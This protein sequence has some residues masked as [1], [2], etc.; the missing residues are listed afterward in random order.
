MPTFDEIV[1]ATNSKKAS[2]APKSS[3]ASK[4]KNTESFDAIVKRTNPQSN[5]AGR[6]V[7][8]EYIN[9]FVS[10]VN[11]YFKDSKNA[12][13]TMDRANAQETTRAR[14]DALNRLN[15]QH[16]TIKNWLYDNRTNIS[17]ANY[18]EI[19]KMLDSYKNNSSEIMNMLTERSDAFSKMT[20]DDYNNYLRYK[21][22][23]V[24]DL[25]AGQKEIDDLEAQLAQM[26]QDNRYNDLQQ[27]INPTKPTEPTRQDI[28]YNPHTMWQ[29]G[30]VQ[31]SGITEEEKLRQ[32]IAQKQQYLNQAKHIQESN[33]YADTVN[34]ADFD[35][36][37]DFVESDDT[38]YNWINDA[39]FRE[40]YESLYKDS[41][42]DVNSDSRFT[43]KNYDQINENEIA[44]FNYYYAKGGKKAAK[45]Y[46]DN[47]QETLNKR[48][49]DE[50]FGTVKDNVAAE[51][52]FGVAAG[53]N[54]FGT[55]VMN[56]FK[57]KADYIP[58]SAYQIASGMVREDLADNG[59][60]PEWMGENSLAQIA[61]D[62]VTTTANMA[63][64]I[65]VGMATGGTAGIALMGLSAA[66]GAYQQ[67]LNEGFDKAQARGYSILVGASEAV[68]EKVLGGISAVGGN[69]LGLNAVKNI[70]N[71]DNA[72]KAIA[73]RLGASVWS[74]FKEEY[75][76][77]V[78]DPV[79]RNLMMHTGEDVKLVSYE[80]IYSGILGALTGAFMEAPF[81]IYGETKTA[82]TGRKIK[83]AG[84]VNDLAKIGNT[85][86]PET[87][88]YK[89]AGKVT[90]DTGAYT[91]G[92]LFNEV[93]ARLTEQNISEIAEVLMKEGMGENEAKQ[94]ARIFAY[95]V[96]GGTMPDAFAAAIEADT[97]LA[98]AARQVLF[99]D[100]TTWNQRSQGYRDV[101][102]KLAED[103]VK[104]KTAPASK[105]SAPA[106]N[107]AEAKTE[108]GAE[109]NVEPA[110]YGSIQNIKNGKVT[111]KMTDGTEVDLK[112]ADL[113]PEDSV[114][115]ETIASIDGISAEDASGIFGI[116]KAGSKNSQYDAI[117][118]REAYRY[119]YYGLT[120]KM[121]DENGTF[122]KSLTPE[123]RK[124][125][126]EMGQKARQQKVE[127][128][129]FRKTDAKKAPGK[130]HY[131]GDRTVLNE[132]QQVSLKAM[133]RIAS[134]LGVQ[135][136]IFESEVGKN[137]K[138]IGENGW[139]DPKDGS[140]H[141]DLYAGQDGG[142]T[143]LFTLAHELTHY[144]HQWSLKKF[145]V[146]AD[147]LI[148]EYGKKGVN[149]SKLIR[150]QQ[151]KAKRN[152][153]TISYDTAYEE[154]VADSMEMMLSDGNVM[155]RLEKLKAQDKDL[156]SQIKRFIDDMAAKIRAVYKDMKPDSKEAEFVME[157]GD[158]IY[159]LQ[160]LFTEGL[161]DASENF[162]TAEKNTTDD[163]GVKFSQRKFNKTV[164]DIVYSDDN[165]PFDYRNVFMGETPQSL[166]DLGFIQLPMTITSKHIYTIANKDGRFKGD[167]DHYHNL[168]ANT[169]MELPE[170]LK[171]PVATFVEKDNPRRVII[172]TSKIDASTKPIMVAVEYSGQTRYKT[173][174]NEV[175][176]YANPVTT[177]LG[178]KGSWFLAQIEEAVR[179]GRML[180]ADKKRSQESPS[181]VWSQCPESL[182]SSDFT[183]NID[184]FEQNVKRFLPKEKQIR[185]SW[186]AVKESEEKSK[187][188]KLSDRDNANRSYAEITEEQQKL[189]H[190]ERD[191]AERKRVA[192]NN[193][194]LLKAMGDYSDMFAEMRELLPKRRQGTAT[195][196]ELDR[197]EEIKGLRDKQ[198]KYIAELQESLGLN[199][200]SREETEIRE[201]K[202]ALRVAADEAWAR[203]GAE[204]ENKAIE[205]SGLSAAEYFRK[206]ALKAFKTTANFNEAGYLLP[207]GKLLN[208]SGG[209][210]NHRYRDHREIGEIYEATQGAAALNRFMSDGNIRIM[211]ESPGVDITSGIEPTKE[212]YNALWK[213]IKT[214]GVKDGQFFVDF[215]D[216]DGHRAGNYSYNG[217]INADRII[218]DIKYFY[219]TGAV[220]ESSG[221]TAFLS[222]R[223]TESVTARD[224]LSSTDVATIKNE[225]AKKKLADYQKILEVMNAEDQ[226]LRDIRA[227]IKELSFA[228][229]P[230][231]TKKL[232]DLKFEAI[233]INNHI[234]VY[235]GQ[236]QRMEKELQSVVKRERAKVVKEVEKRDKAVLAKE[237]MD[238][239]VKQSETLREYR[240]TRA[241][242]RQQESDTAV[243]E[244]EFIRIAKEY[245]KLDAKSGKTISE[246][247]TKL[248]NEA[249]KHRADEK[250]WMAEFGRLMREYE[251]A[252]RS[253]DRL[254]QKI[255]RQKAVAKERVEGRNKT[256][257]RHKIR[258]IVKDLDKILNRG[259]KK[260]NVKEDMKGFASKA[261]ELADYL[262]A[263]HIS[264]EDL[265]R[266]GI[267][268]RMTTEEAALV[269]ETENILF[270]LYDNADNLTDAEFNLLDS[271]RK[272]N[273][274]KLRDLLAEQRNKYLDT[275]VYNL[276]N[277]L[278][279]E[280]ASLKNST[281]DAVRAAYNHDVERFLRSYIGDSAD[282]TDTDRKTLLQNMR[283]K[284]MT[285]D[286]LWKIHNAY[287]MVLHS[288]R[289]ANEMFVKGKAESVDEVT[290]AI[291]WDFGSKKIPN[292]KAAIIA[293][294]LSNKIG[295]DYE[296]LYYALD[297]IG[298]EAFTELVM[299]VANSENIV[300]QDVME[301]AAFRDEMVEKYG[302]NS[303]DVNKEI[304]REFLDTTG[305]KFK[306]TLGQMMALYAYS[307]RE[308]AWD[309]I[310]YGGFVFGDAA[311]T[312]PRPA[313]AYKLSKEQ[314]EAITNLLTE[315]QKGY[316]KSMQRFL[317]ETMGEK[318]NEVS[319]LMYGIKMFNEKNYFPIHM[320]GQFKA[321]A[322][323]SQAKAAAGF[324]SMSNAGFTHAQNPNAKA[325]FVLEGFNEVWVDHVN[326]M[327][328]Y[329][330]T[331]PALEDMRRVMNRSTYSNSTES[332]VSIKQLMENSF[333]KEAV[334]YFDDFY[335]EANAGAITDKLQ[336]RSQKLLSLFRKNSVA[337]SLSVL[338]QQPTSI[339]RAYAMI[340]PRYFGYKGVGA[341][342][343]GVVKTA[344]NKW[345]NAQ[346]KAYNEMLKYAPGVTMAKE[347]GGFDTATGG[348]IRSY[349]LDTNKSFKQKWKT[350]TA[351]EKGKAVMDLVDDNAVANLPNLA[352]KIAWIEI[353]N[354]C[355]R[356]SLA[357]HTNLRPSSD[358]LLQIAGKR[359]TEVIRATQVYDSM[360]AKSPM[361]KSKNLFVQS[362][363]SFMNEPNTVANMAESA[364]RDFV[365]GDKKSGVRKAAV[366]VNS[367]IATCVLKSIV[368][369]MRDDDEDE[370]Y[371][372][373]YV[374]ALTG[375]LMDDFNL[376]NYIPIARD[377]WSL[378]QGYD[379]E[380][381]DMAIVADAIEALG[382]VIKNASTETG[383]MTEEQ[384]IEFDKQCTE[385]NWKLAESLATFLGIPM[386]NI[387]REI[388]GI[389][390][391]ARTSSANKGL[392]TKTSLS[393][394]AY[395]AV[396]DSIP[397]L[398]G[399]K[400]KEEKL[401]EARMNSDE[402][403]A[404]RLASSYK[405]E[406]A[407]NSAVT[408]AIKNRYKNG[409]LDEA[410]ALKHL[411]LYAGK[412]GTE[413]HWTMDEWKYQ[414]KKGT[415]EGYSKYYKIYEAIKNGES[416]TEAVEELVSNGSK[417][418]EV[419]SEVKSSIGEW[420]RKG[421][422]TKK[423]ATDMLTDYFDLDSD[424]IEATIQKWSSKV[425]TGIA[426]DDIKTEYMDGNITSAQA[427]DM[428]VKYGGYTKKEAEET[429]ADYDFENEYG[430]SYSNR[431]TAY[432]EGIVSS[433]EMKSILMEHGNLN[434]TDAEDTVKAYEFLKNH[435]Q[436]DLDVNDAKKFTVR[437]GD[438]CKDRTLTDFGVSVESYLEYV[439]GAKNCKGVDADGDGYAD[440]NTKAIQLFDMIDKLPISSTAKD[441]LAYITNAK[442]TI[443]KYAPWHQ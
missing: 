181:G 175:Q 41:P 24:Y 3:S 144:I 390:N 260:N 205:K 65:L 119:G 257:M 146:L 364:M 416:I 23:E 335:R 356:E 11:N 164:D 61:Y 30:T 53:V 185:K 322:N 116:L 153:R 241:A 236:L 272:R 110:K 439:K 87:V 134:A 1:K 399:K 340:D 250:M 242:L 413:A 80:A 354:A 307:R 67:A 265:I 25:E 55:N 210:R 77:E 214:N 86:A 125:V 208:F 213:F 22:Q 145:D 367:I 325:P 281:Q 198:L 400:T 363:V 7:D 184:R 207:D 120:E 220:R 215:S 279:T 284:D 226:K 227:E 42:S 64:S 126:Y 233:K 288:I 393:D 31:T 47:I 275:P 244:K 98:S 50:V 85:F 352:D 246:L 66:G 212:Q 418:N 36:F 332:S 38:L 167:D 239:Q 342:T 422:I 29:Q 306:L 149:V 309:H 408:E 424:E 331:V 96:E 10:G 131:D 421:E 380:R 402:Q 308:G 432:K 316:V 115:I 179:D 162:Q 89:L 228:K 88:A 304:D 113:D 103:K 290:K 26:E 338:I 114:R 84:I 127:N 357:K 105:A 235:E 386:K 102:M 75:L 387:R 93:N 382:R 82:I 264:N 5:S 154:F 109:G 433:S 334:E 94:N 249:K 37:D 135:I 337:Y 121:L 336:K 222:D 171:N 287:T 271:K 104:G 192:N 251:A 216:K 17:S 68:L 132:R 317:S 78:L 266:K 299:N 12:Y 259:N 232:K 312:N 379:V 349:L 437:I 420:Y 111:V 48:K 206:K 83:E 122:S 269:K 13:E 211:A 273:L 396:I 35:Q 353:W 391:L 137:G 44:I 417:E 155:K 440:R 221:L 14:Q 268:V 442:G 39:Q 384:L 34:N 201:E 298:S 411:V 404:S 430:F 182:W 320:A 91:I 191:L 69:A 321:Q 423:E 398:N 412:D 431:V 350:G 339:T 351:L 395:N 383:S 100:N 133:D 27:R 345:T 230:K 170:L 319:M 199:E 190:R 286:E 323:E 365:R 305:K 56:N 136:Y 223:D 375:S 106:D 95:I 195:Q 209:E 397:F 79:F 427:V 301:A 253:I 54:Q 371:I 187:N 283:A 15:Q 9:S 311:L 169:V 267:T 293:R 274:D 355:K 46:L 157:M 188:L 330:G 285:M 51:L 224:L 333:G 327:S 150:E 434:E 441:G 258:K 374:E 389:L 318:G 378:T 60:L 148:E 326:E 194:E 108:S 361:L 426:Y 40:E 343:G 19:F 90:N 276:F 92:Q 280:Y 263:D 436:Y 117:G 49:A 152:G 72:L 248:K 300:M 315:E 200:I 225:V 255:E 329:H 376:L 124:A 443:N 388:M 159:R 303:W 20:D 160:E 174:T 18:Y 368:Y 62:A 58:Q 183:T 366:L 270:Q 341:I 70:A 372:E 385:A 302:F 6:K 141:I 252:D 438:K 238:A 139:Y 21:D 97:L 112:D 16:D 52:V 138:R 218:N 328:R 254:E 99:E 247:R 313:D 405:D 369:A 76:Q 143:M 370:T 173:A 231:D 180:Q 163:G 256:A 147:F 237:W 297:R 292:K 33:A 347:I 176:I 377:V 324:Q 425:D 401:Y 203:E 196:T 2:T 73:K 314:C 414:T 419:M 151:N 362:L 295:W 130:V 71:A 123:Q 57:F 128:T 142:A 406:K 310:E 177:A 407:A 358:E 294:N 118:A 381:A 186:G 415:G 4:P 204:K 243:M 8:N 81:A 359:F 202:E 45:K 166:L 394:S 282:G 296:K 348:S 165:E 28:G 428:Y 219:Q 234:S 32:L 197:I 261:L 410:T 373:K 189:Y 63:P 229:A 59:K 360:F 217:R 172:V 158:T 240:E 156:W 392:T 403:Y 101:L 107:T 277:D 245:E 74:E 129:T 289:K 409:K 161:M 435:Q 262:F 291:T 346:T 178:K 344:A 278:V 43:R 140:I 429:I 193:P 168:G